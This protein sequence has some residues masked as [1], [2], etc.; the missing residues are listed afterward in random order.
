MD[1]TFDDSGKLILRLALGILILMHGIAKVT[2]DISG[3][4]GMLV[5]AG[6]PAILA[7]G[8]Y[9]GEVLAPIL[10]ILG[11]Y[12]RIGAL[13]IAITMVFAIGLAHADELFLLTATGGWALELQGMFLFAAIALVLTGPGRLSINR[14]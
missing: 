7:Y 13:L 14:L 3:I 9:V 12:A 10:V 4:E 1:N 11:L 2:G 5:T 8:V 6:L